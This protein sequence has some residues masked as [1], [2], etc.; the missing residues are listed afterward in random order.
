[1]ADAAA[2]PAEV[3]KEWDW[4]KCELR[5]R[6]WG[7]AHGRRFGRGYLGQRFASRGGLCFSCNW[8]RNR[9]AK[10]CKGSRFRLQHSHERVACLRGFKS[11]E[12]L[13]YARRRGK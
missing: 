3:G 4:K 11:E 8:D 2:A 5:Y 7:K 9:S 13:R 6:V 1:M 10:G 12:L